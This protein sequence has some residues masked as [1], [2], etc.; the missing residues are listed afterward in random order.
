MRFIFL[1]YKREP[2]NID[3]P[4]KTI[5]VLVQSDKKIYFQ[6]SKDLKK[7]KEYDPSLDEF[8][9]K[10]LGETISSLI[11]EKSVPVSS[12]KLQAGAE[13]SPSDIEFLESLRKSYQG[14]V[15]FSDIRQA[16]YPDPKKG[17]DE[18]YRQYVDP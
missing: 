2:L 10:G 3:D 16:N 14:K 9:V 15:Q 12:P 1:K 5:G 7:L 11:K 8:V 6:Y 4:G 13:T 17:M 18:L